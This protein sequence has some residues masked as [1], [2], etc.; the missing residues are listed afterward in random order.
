MVE[1]QERE[2]KQSL[3]NIS[4]IT[5]FSKISMVDTCHLSLLMKAQEIDKH[6][7]TLNANK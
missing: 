3:F 7:N 1:K 5:Y 6:R 2:V 4:V